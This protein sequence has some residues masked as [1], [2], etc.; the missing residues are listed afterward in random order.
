MRVDRYGG[1][2][3]YQYGRN[4]FLTNVEEMLF[5]KYGS[6]ALQSLCFQRF[7]FNLSRAET[8]AIFLSRMKYLRRKMTIPILRGENF[9]KQ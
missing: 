9:V 2:D 6:D 7:N 5:G 4:A 8:F 3:V 1:D